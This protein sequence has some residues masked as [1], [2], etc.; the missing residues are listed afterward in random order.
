MNT[1][2]FTDSI[3]KNIR[4]N[5]FD[6]LIKN[7][8]AKM[9]NIPG[10]S[11]R[12]LLHY[13]DIHLGGIQVYTV[14]IHSGVNGL[15]NY[16][17]QSRID[18]LMNKIICMVE[19]CRIY[20]V[21]IIFLSGRVFTTRVSLDILLQ[22]HSMISNFFNTNGQNHIDNRNIRANCLYKDGLHLSNKG[23]IVLANNFIINSNKK[24]LTTH[25]QHP[26]STRCYM[27]QECIPKHTVNSVEATLQI[28]QDDRVTFH[29]NPILG[30]VNINSLR[31]KITD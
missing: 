4:M 9:L 19:K 18:S 1:L 6:K 24:I 3:P 29:N 28:L 14:I 27:N 31:N 5:D 2:I 22:V 16:N 23:K 12:Q 15:L 7:R 21:K 8:K 25:L 17:N 26:T 30:Y 20:G 13:M 11:S 10:A